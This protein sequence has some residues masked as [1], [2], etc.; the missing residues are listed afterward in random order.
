MA[1]ATDAQVLE[2][3]ADPGWLMPYLLRLDTLV[4]DLPADVAVPGKPKG[5]AYQFEG[6][7]RWGY[8][9][10]GVWEGRTP[11]GP[12]PF[13]HFRRQPYPEDE[14]AITDVLRRYVEKGLGGWDDAWM[15]LVVW[16][17]HGFGHHTDGIDRELSRIPDAIKAHW[18]RTFNLATL[19][20]SPCDWSAHIL[21]GGLRAA[22]SHGY[23]RYEGSGYF[24]TPMD[25]VEMMTEITFGDIPTEEQKVMTVLDPCCGTGSMLLYASNYC[26]RLFG[27]DIVFDLTLCTVLNGYLFA[28]W[29]VMMP[30]YMDEVLDEHRARMI[31]RR[32]KPEPAPVDL[33]ALREAA[34]AGELAQAELF[35]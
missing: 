23:N 20:H 35:R 34:R 22:G 28:P 33:S 2:R 3:Q 14:K 21:Q 24:A 9:M 7:G 13:I 17:L 10:R 26:L 27:Q 29:M 15:A 25:V 30:G 31:A 32:G 18:Y 11:E 8:W 12:I 6:S 4:V 1:T 19:L 16:V 5:V